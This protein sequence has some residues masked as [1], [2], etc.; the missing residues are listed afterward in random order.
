[1]TAIP[2]ALLQ[3]ADGR[4]P[5]GGHAHS[6]GVEAAAALL[7]V[8][9]ASSLESFVAGSLTTSGLVDASFAAA[10]AGGADPDA[11]DAERDVRFV[12]AHVRNASRALGRQLVRAAHGTWPDL[13]TG[14]VGAALAGPPEGGW[15][16]SIAFGLVGR[17]LGV[18]AAPLA[19][20]S[21]HQSAATMLGAYVRLRG[22]DPAA[23]QAV[24]A[25]LG[26][27]I[28]S[29]SAEAASAGE[30]PLAEL[31]VWSGPAADIAAE[32]HS[33]W[34]VRLFGT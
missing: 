20:V 31:P 33:G 21:L 18:G 8:A 13:A 28:E 3:L 7:G 10:V 30:G 5:S 2:P 32:D 17:G 16:Q 29:V 22:L 9:D 4:F 25:R 27:L 14:P 24:L 6:F 19:Q 11:A 15:H 34:E 12:V 1:M 23:A 26:P